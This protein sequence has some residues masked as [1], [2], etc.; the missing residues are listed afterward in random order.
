[1][2]ASKSIEILPGVYGV[3]YQFV[4]KSKTVT[5]FDDLVATV[6]T[7]PVP[8]VLTSR[9]NEREIGNNINI[10]QLQFETPIVMVNPTAENIPHLERMENVHQVITSDKKQKLYNKCAQYCVDVRNPDGVLHDGIG[11]YNTVIYPNDL[12]TKRKI[13]HKIWTQDDIRRYNLI[14]EQYYSSLVDTMYGTYPSGV[15]AYIE[16]LKQVTYP[17]SK[18]I[19]LA[20]VDISSLPPKDQLYIKS[21][22]HIKIID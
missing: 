5:S 4:N 14:D 13:I 2:T 19:A 12:Y 17:D 7:K 8:S 20:W 22:E 3:E 16:Y 15:L 21:C 18:F 9:W 6:N 11:P 1:M 10:R